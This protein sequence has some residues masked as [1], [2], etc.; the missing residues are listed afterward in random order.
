MKHIFGGF[1]NSS[2]KRI[3]NKWCPYKGGG[4]SFLFLLSGANPSFHI[5]QK[6]KE[7]NELQASPSYLFMFG[8][9]DLYISDNCNDNYNSESKF[10]S[11]YELPNGISIYSEAAN[12]YLAG[13]STFKV[14]EIEVF[15]IVLNISQ[16]KLS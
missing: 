1:A 4:K 9:G 14:E 10:G 8:N 11:S 3:D 13:K 15:K 2:F 6:G 16:W 7:S 5:L 12:S